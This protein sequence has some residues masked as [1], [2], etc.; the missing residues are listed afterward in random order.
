M[1]GKLLLV[2]NPCAGQRRAT[3][4]LAELV[5][6]FSDFDWETTVYVTDGKNDAQEYV[7]KRA[8]D[9]ERIVCAGGDG[10]LNEVFSGVLLS[11]TKRPIGYLPAGTTND[12][13][14]TLGLSR[15]MVTAGHDVMTGVEREMDVGKINGRYFAYT[16]SFGAFTRTAYSTPQAAK[17]AL[18]HLAYLLEGIKD[19]PQIRPIHMKIDADGR[20][21][22]DDFIFGAVNNSTSVGGILRLDAGVVGMDDGRFEVILVKNPQNANQLSRTVLALT[23][24]DF[25]CDMLYFFPA[26][27]LRISC[28]ADVCWTRDGEYESGSEQIEIENLHR[29]VRF[30]VPRTAHVEAED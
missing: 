15:D 19:I 6:M 1:A 26:T 13:A 16:A 10:T 28:P 22:E 29:A 11:G 24:N 17:N 27:K 2:V 18:G 4:C 8:G 23:K 3:K 30:I 14:E 12:Y 9:F 7:T 20:E 5:R 25:L 21:Y